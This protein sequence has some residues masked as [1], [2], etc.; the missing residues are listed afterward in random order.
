MGIAGY[1]ETCSH[2]AMSSVDASARPS[3]VLIP[4]AGGMAWYWH[5]VVPLLDQARRE[6]IPVDLSGDD[7]DA[8]LDDYSERTSQR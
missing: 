4:G 2:I 7:G 1:V 8:N 6:A 3:F 5:R